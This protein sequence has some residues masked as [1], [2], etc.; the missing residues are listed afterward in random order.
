MQGLNQMQHLAIAGVVKVE[1]K[2]NA[3]LKEIGIFPL[4]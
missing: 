4:R 1:K 2:C 3:A